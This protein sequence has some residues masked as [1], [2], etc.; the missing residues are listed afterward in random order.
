MSEIRQMEPPFGTHRL[1]APM[2]G[3]RAATAHL[4][5]NRV[6]RALSSLVRRIVSRG[7][8]DPIDAEVFPGIRTRLR[9]GT[10]SPSSNSIIRA[11][12]QIGFDME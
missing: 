9:P 10:N 3:L 4:P 2:E 11:T 5:A 1:S 7:P 6:G 12:E 8:E